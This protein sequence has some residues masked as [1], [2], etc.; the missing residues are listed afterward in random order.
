[1]SE[2][3]QAVEGTHNGSWYTDTLFIASLNVWFESRTDEC[4]M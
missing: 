4:I 2:T 1:M 3:V